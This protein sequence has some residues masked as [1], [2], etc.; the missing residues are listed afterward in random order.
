METRKAT[1]ESLRNVTP[2]S[3]VIVADALNQVRDKDVI[4]VDE[5]GLGYHYL[6][7]LEALATGLSHRRGHALPFDGGTIEDCGA[8][9]VRLY[10][11]NRLV[12]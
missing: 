12:I 7:R 3:P 4:V 6:D 8:G 10:P 11:P 1:I 5:M 2:I 9:E